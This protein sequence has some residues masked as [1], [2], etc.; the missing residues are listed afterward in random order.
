MFGGVGL[1]FHKTVDFTGRRDKSAFQH[2]GDGIL[3]K[4]ANVNFRYVMHP[5]NVDPVDP[6]L[7][8]DIYILQAFLD[9]ELPNRQ[10]SDSENRMPRNVEKVSDNLRLHYH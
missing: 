8:F 6:P 3:R 5:D 10:A 1:M 9:E 7:K 2:P 4:S